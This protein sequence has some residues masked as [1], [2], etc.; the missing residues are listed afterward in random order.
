MEQGGTGL[1]QPPHLVVLRGANHIIWSSHPVYHQS[2]PPIALTHCLKG[3]Y[4]KHGEKIC[5]VLHSP[6]WGRRAGKVGS[7]GFGYADSYAAVYGYAFGYVE[8]DASQ[9]RLRRQ[10][11]VWL[12]PQYRC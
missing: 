6:T 2:A 3:R 5:V 7:G 10:T 1:E 9:L 12:R 11:E 8:G 4:S